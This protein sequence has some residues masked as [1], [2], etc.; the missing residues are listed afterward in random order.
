MFRR[1]L[2]AFD[3][4]SHAQRALAEAIELAEAN[5][6]RLTVM[7]VVPEP[8]AWALGGYGTPVDLRDLTNQIE[9]EYQ[10]MLD[11]A[12]D[13]VPDDLPVTKVLKRGAAG[14]AIVEQAS[15]DN[16]DLIV[17]GSRGRGELRSLLLGSVSHHVLQAS[18]LPVLVIR[19]SGEFDAVD[20]RLS[21]SRSAAASRSGSWPGWAF[22]PISAG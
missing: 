2:V 17:M 1:L 9:R 21:V 5:S 10:T 12:I 22:L 4:S 7:T 11:V 15:S 8:S 14:R 3:G 19:D 18:P 20:Q 13:T 16:H 6:G